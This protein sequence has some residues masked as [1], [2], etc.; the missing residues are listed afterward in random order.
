M[1]I[2]HGLSVDDADGGVRV[3]ARDWP[4]AAWLA[5]PALAAGLPLVVWSAATLHWIELGGG[6]KSRHVVSAGLA[7]GGA[8]Q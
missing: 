6:A 8:T 3:T 1:R 4:W 7:A 2:A 5:A